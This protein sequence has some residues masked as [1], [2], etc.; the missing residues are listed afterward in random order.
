MWKNPTNTLKDVLTYNKNK[1]ITIISLIFQSNM[2][3]FFY[4][5]NLILKAFLLIISFII[6]SKVN[7]NK[8]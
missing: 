6:I 4:R 1:D 3:I 8:T 5:F 7:T 2:R